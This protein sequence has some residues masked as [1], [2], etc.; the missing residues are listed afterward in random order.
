MIVFLKSQ[1]INVPGLRAQHL[2]MYS[3]YLEYNENLAKVYDN[4]VE[5]LEEA[6]FLRFAKQKWLDL[7][8]HIYKV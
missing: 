6:D 8:F 2:L 3:E 5:Y 4:D 7:F 1:G